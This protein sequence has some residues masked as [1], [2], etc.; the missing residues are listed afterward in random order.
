MKT[1]IVLLSSLLVPSIAF[2]GAFSIR[3]GSRKPA[4]VSDS[5]QNPFVGQ[6][7]TIISQDVD[8]S[9]TEPP[10]L[11]D[12]REFVRNNPINGIA[13]H[14]KVEYRSVLL[15]R[16][17]MLSVGSSIPTDLFAGGGGFV[18]SEILPNQIV[19]QPVGRKDY[20]ISFPSNLYPIPKS[21]R[22]NVQGAKK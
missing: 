1:K 10:G 13:W 11:K 22:T 15:G 4:D 5:V 3:P 12:L 7:M 9:A 2:A 21:Q 6:S 20:P 8:P 17:V 16:D 14:E 19:F 18:V